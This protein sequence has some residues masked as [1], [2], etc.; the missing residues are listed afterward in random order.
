MVSGRVLTEPNDKGWYGGNVTVRWTVTMRVT[1][2]AP[3]DTVVTAEGD[4]LT[5]TSPQVC[6]TRGNCRQARCST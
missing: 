2:P 3:A 4:D 6:D 5:V 1:I